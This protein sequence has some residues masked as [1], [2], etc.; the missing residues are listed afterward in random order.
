M[1]TFSQSKAR[2]KTYESSQEFDLDMARLFEKARRWHEPCTEPYGR[3]LLLQVSYM[4]TLPSRGTDSLLS[5]SIRRSHPLLRLL[6]LPTRLPQ[7]SPPF[8]QVQAL[9]DR[10]MPRTL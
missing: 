2:A 6:A 3:V 9:R 10:T 8:A 1:L 5:V 4:Y 7:T